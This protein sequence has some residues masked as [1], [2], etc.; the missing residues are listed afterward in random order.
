MSTVCECTK[1][2]PDALQCCEITA[3]RETVSRLTRAVQAIERHLHPMVERSGDNMDKPINLD[4]L[5][6]RTTAS[7]TRV[8]QLEEQIAALAH[9]VNA[10]AHGH[11]SS[12]RLRD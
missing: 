4:D 2:N 10:V 12:P 9:A 1:K 7:E 8:Q 3:L 5:V 11:G 6:R